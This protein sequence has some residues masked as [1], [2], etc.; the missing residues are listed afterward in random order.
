MKPITSS[1][2]DEAIIAAVEVIATLHY[3][4]FFARQSHRFNG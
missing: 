1:N 4:P 3:K 2:K